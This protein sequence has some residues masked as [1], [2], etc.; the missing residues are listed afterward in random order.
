MRPRLLIGTLTL[1][2]GAVHALAATPP[3]QPRSGPGGLE[4]PSAEVVQR[5]VG[6]AS[7]ATYVYH[8]EHC[9]RCGTA[10]QT[11]E[12]GGRPCYFCPVCQ[13]R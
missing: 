2:L 5:G 11:V 12:L 13:P 10:V 3:A 4:N 7:A 1:C 9:L 8:R 6:R